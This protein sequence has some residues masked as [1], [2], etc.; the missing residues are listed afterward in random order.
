MVNRSSRLFLSLAVYNFHGMLSP[1]QIPLRL[2]TG[3]ADGEQL[4]AR[5]DNSTIYELQKGTTPFP[6]RRLRSPEQIILQCNEPDTMSGLP[7]NIHDLCASSVSHDFVR[8]NHV[9]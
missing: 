6:E 4:E 3:G 7:R 5:R 9:L 2:S 1:T 8:M